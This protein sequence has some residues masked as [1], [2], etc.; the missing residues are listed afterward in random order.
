MK[1]KGE[2]G[3]KPFFGVDRP[4]TEDI[5]EPGARFEGSLLGGSKDLV[6]GYFKDS[7]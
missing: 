4:Y 6:T 1:S 2:G 3:I 5:R 7:N